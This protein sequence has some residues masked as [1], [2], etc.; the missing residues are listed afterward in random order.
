MTDLYPHFSYLLDKTSEQRAHYLSNNIV[1]NEDRDMLERLLSN[2][3]RMS[4]D[5]QWLEEM[6]DQV[7]HFGCCDLEQ[8]AGLQI[9][10]YRLQELLGK[11]GMGAVYLAHRNDGL[12]EQRL[13]FKFLY[14]S[15]ATV[16]GE[17]LKHEAQLLAKIRHPAITQV[18]DAGSTTDGLQYIMMEY[19]EGKPFDKFLQTCSLDIEEKLQL[20]LKL[21]DAICAT[22]ALNIVHGDLKPAN[23]LV[24]ESL[25]IKLLDFGIAKQ[26]QQEQILSTRL[27]LHAMSLPYA[28]PEQLEATPVST[29]SDQY[30]LGSLLYLCL[31]GRPALASNATSFAETL[32]LKKRAMPPV[33][34]LLPT[35]AE[36]LK[37]RLQLETVVQKVLAI[38]PQERY[39]SVF[40]LREQL[41]NYLHQ[42]PLQHQK[43]WY[44]RTG[45]WLQRNP[46]LTALIGVLF[47]GFSLLA[48]QNQQIRL[49]RNNAEQV[50]T[51]LAKLFQ[52]TDPRAQQQPEVKA[53]ELLR[54]GEV[55][56]T[57]D[58]DLSMDL[59]WQLLQVIA[60]SYFNIGDYTRAEQL[61]RTL[62]NQQISA[63]QVQADTLRFYCTI[64]E[65]F[66]APFSPSL[67]E[68]NAISDYFTDL[69][70]TELLTPEHASAL[71]SLLT[72]LQ[73]NVDLL[74]GYG[75]LAPHLPKLVEL[76]PNN[77]WKMASLLQTEVRWEQ[78]IEQ[79]EAGTID[80]SQWLELKG[81]DLS[82][83]EQSIAMT[84]PLHPNYVDLIAVALNL[85]RIVDIQIHRPELPR[86]LYQQLE[87]SIRVRQQMLGLSQGSVT[88][89]LDA[90]ILSAEYL[91]DWSLMESNINRLERHISKMR[92]PQQNYSLLL[93]QK[94]A[95]YL[96]Q[97]RH[98]DLI[99]LTQQLVDDLSK[100]PQQLSH[101]SFFHLNS[102]A[103]GLTAFE[104]KQALAA[105]IPWLEKALKSMVIDTASKEVYQRQL[106]GRQAWA[107]GKLTFAEIAD[108]IKHGSELT[109][110]LF[111]E[112]ALLSGQNLRVQQQLERDLENVEFRLKLCP[113]TYCSNTMLIT[114]LPLKLAKIKLSENNIAAARP[115][116][117]LVQ[118]YAIKSNNALSNTWLKQ[119]QELKLQYSID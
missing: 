38:N 16:A 42:R 111:L 62:F 39:A 25:Q 94:A 73:A 9:G 1:N 72:S 109:T 27:Y 60:E 91:D 57:N 52:A 87:Q 32:L 96:R 17:A 115:L 101:Y 45:K 22:H 64:S 44:W 56:I 37:V 81:K 21:V 58:Q 103:D 41:E 117:A 43:Q 118:N 69:S 98:Q 84:D 116:L 35:K 99:I 46:M 97:G 108:P 4:G 36:R 107:L 68:L 119:V 74:K 88:Q 40:E 113:P 51:H 82:I 105:L 24:T 63:G 49:E 65:Y 11:G 112:M 79:L 110:E 67:T 55:D 30:A 70:E 5:T 89:A 19:V 86:Q 61:T 92:K 3:E 106:T 53:T 6:K 23:I 83:I 31:T 26:V 78:H 54:L 77:R 85:S 102:V 59:R 15:V 7:T 12:F 50:A 75:Q 10:P 29:A 18:I 34:P 14:P 71:L 90:A 95:L 48:M 33:W 100:E 28:A 20:F 8:L 104:E 76:Y 66:K 13:A 2:C 80:E 93:R 47:C 114:V